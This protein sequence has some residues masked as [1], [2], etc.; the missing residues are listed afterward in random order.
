MR[1]SIPYP[2]LPMLLERSVH[3]RMYRDWKERNARRIADEDRLKDLGLDSL[4][5]TK[6]D[7][8]GIK[9]KDAAV[10]DSGNGRNV[11]ST[12][13]VCRDD[14]G[15]CVAKKTSGYGSVASGRDQT[16]AQ[17]GTN[18]NSTNPNVAAKKSSHVTGD[19][20]WLDCINPTEHK[21][22]KLA[23]HVAKQKRIRD[24]YIRKFAPGTLVG[25]RTPEVAIELPDNKSDYDKSRSV[26]DKV[27]GIALQHSPMDKQ[28]WLIKFQNQKLFYLHL[29]LLSFEKDVVLDLEILSNEEKDI[30]FRARF[31][32][33]AKHY[34]HILKAVLFPLTMKLPEHCPISVKGIVQKLKPFHP[35]LHESSLREYI[36]DFRNKLSSNKP[37]DATIMINNGETYKSLICHRTSSA[38][39]STT[40]SDKAK[41]NANSNAVVKKTV[42]KSTQT[43]SMLST[44]TKSERKRDR[45]LANSRY[46]CNKYN[47]DYSSDEDFPS[48]KLATQPMFDKQYVKDANK[49]GIHPCKLNFD[50]VLSSGKLKLLLCNGTLL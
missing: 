19:S 24:E 34:E 20:G 10:A 49:I 46:Y 42:D 32:H 18:V 12:D 50:E 28:T 14:V 2:I 30:M 40:C 27:L 37:K 33:M 8:F 44:G 6:V 25:S 16:L 4:S 22:A 48:S 17:R 5:D 29:N 36:V 31:D 9:S 26:R 13:A 43:D 3:N 7:L 1:I 45:R 38:T 15:S 39:C 21:E 11:T 47:N 41:S 23:A 35:W